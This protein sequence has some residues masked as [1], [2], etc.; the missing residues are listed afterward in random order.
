MTPEASYENQK[1]LNAFL[2]GLAQSLLENNDIKSKALE[3]KDI[4]SSGEF[5]HSYSEIFPIV[6]Q[7]FTDENYNAEFLINNLAL[8]RGFAEKDYL[9][10]EGE[11]GK[12]E[13]LAVI[14]LC[15]HINL[16][17]ARLNYSTKLHSDLETTQKL[18]SESTERNSEMQEALKQSQEALKSSQAALDKST[19]K[20]NDAQNKLSNTQ[21]QVVA[22]LSIFAAIVITFAGGISLLGNALSSVAEASILNLLL[23]VLVVGIVLVNGITALIYTVSRIVGKS[24]YAKCIREE[25]TCE[26]DGKP[27]CNSLKKVMKRLPFVFWINIV[28]IGLLVITTAL[29]ILNIF[30]CFI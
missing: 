16:E 21:G 10:T 15:D 13:V 17:L 4:Y 8:I 7:V 27:L 2:F 12:K 1:K 26:K 5:R 28:L 3:L 23:I 29:Y 30:Y 14:K 19:Q 11:F 24:I 6:T 25:C 9:Q 18:L 22:I 20:L